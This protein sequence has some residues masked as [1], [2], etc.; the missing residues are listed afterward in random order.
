MAQRSF[1]QSITIA[2]APAQVAPFFAS[3]DQHTVLHPLIVAIRPIAA[4]PAAPDARWYAIT[5]RMQ[6]G[7]LRFRFTYIA[8]LRDAGG[9]TFISDAFQFPRVHLHNITRC[10][11]EGS[12]T[13]VDEHIT[14]D[15]PRLLIGYVHQQAFL[16]H[17]ELLARLKQHVE[18]AQSAGMV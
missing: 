13:R 15:A 18:A 9:G 2:A 12:G 17:R 5:D 6:I 7:P 11:P 4:R 10:Q 16:A 3:Y 14:I 1:E 8:A